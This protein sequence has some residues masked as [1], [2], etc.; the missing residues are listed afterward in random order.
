MKLGFP[1]LP[2]GISKIAMGAASIS[3]GGPD[4]TTGL[5]F[6]PK[7]LILIATGTGGVNQIL[8]I[9]FSNKTTDRYRAL[10]G[11]SVDAISGSGIAVVRK[12]ASNY[13]T[14]VVTSFDADGFTLTWTLVGVMTAGYTWLAMR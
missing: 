7:V 2:P 1:L 8:S 13:I 9:G 3:A 14:A 4:S 6:T 5:G 10:I 11:D 12:D